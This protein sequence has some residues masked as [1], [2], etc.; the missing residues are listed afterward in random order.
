MLSDQ[1]YYDCLEELMS[2][3]KPEAPWHRFHNEAIQGAIHIIKKFKHDYKDENSQNQ[4]TQLPEIEGRGDDT[5]PHQLNLGEEQT[6][7]DISAESN[8]DS[9]V[10]EV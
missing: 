8:R 7:E 10:G 3:K 5:I 4:H 1:E 2:L 6:G 9:S